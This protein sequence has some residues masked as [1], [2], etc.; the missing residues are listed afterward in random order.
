MPDLV[1]RTIGRKKRLQKIWRSPAW[2]KA[3]QEFKKK[4]PWCEFHLEYGIKI[5]T[6]TAHHPYKDSY[7]VEEIYLDF[8]LSECQAVCQQCHKAIDV[9]LRICPICKE[10]YCPFTV[11]RC[12]KCRD[13]LDPVNAS[14]RKDLIKEKKEKQ[15]LER[16]AQNKK[17]Y[18]E[19]KIKRAETTEKREARL[20]KQRKYRKEQ[21][22]KAKEKHLSCT[23]SNT[24]VRKKK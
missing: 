24:S 21:Y 20:E 5:P 14:I 1:K 10:N 18:Q 13:K 11:D 8:Y 12:S 7:S 3:M 17:K 4:N 19:Q 2:K 15:R 16:N 9:G 6:Y 22:K 23:T